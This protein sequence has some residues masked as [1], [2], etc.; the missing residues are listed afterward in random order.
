MKWDE[1]ISVQFDNFI[2]QPTHIAKYTQEIDPL[3]E[4]IKCY[5]IVAAS[6]LLLNYF[7]TGQVINADIHGLFAFNK[8]FRACRI[9]VD[10]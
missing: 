2:N 9:R 1:E 8:K 7:P 5:F 6:E 4:C 10:F 3:F